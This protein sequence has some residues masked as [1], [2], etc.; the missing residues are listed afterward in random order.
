MAPTQF[1][2]FFDP[3]IAIHIDL[4]RKYHVIS[5]YNIVGPRFILMQDSVEVHITAI[6]IQ[7]L[8]K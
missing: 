4:R 1:R 3:T 6:M 5:A 7:I 2:D 8:Q